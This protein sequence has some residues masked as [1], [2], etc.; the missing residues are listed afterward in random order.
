MQS[1]PDEILARKYE[2]EHAK[3]KHTVC[4][5]PVMTQCWYIWK[6]KFPNFL[7]VL[8]HGS[9]GLAWREISLFVCPYSYFCDRVPFV[10]DCTLLS[11]AEFASSAHGLLTRVHCSEAEPLDHLRVC[12]RTHLKCGQPRET[13]TQ[14]RNSGM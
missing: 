5:G 14:H 7:T 1:Q 13:R 12:S 9:V 6:A 4:G 11:F 8:S 10:H 3:F 2:A